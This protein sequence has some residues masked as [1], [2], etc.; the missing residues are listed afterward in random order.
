METENLSR[1]PQ[2]FSSMGEISSQQLGWRIAV[3][4]FRSE[5]A[6]AGYE[7][8]LGMAEEISAAFSRYRSPR[9]ISPVTFWDGAGPSADFIGRCQFY[10]LD[11]VIEGTIQ[12]IADKIHVDVM[13]S[14][15]V[16][17]FEAIWGGS[18]DGRMDDLCYLQ[19]RIVAVAISQ[20]DPDLLQKALPVNPLVRTKIAAAHQAVL[21]AIQW[22][23]QLDRAQFMRAGELLAVAIELDPEYAAAH[24]WIAYWSIIAVSLGWASKPRA[25]AIAAGKSA[26]R[27]IL[28]NPSNARALAIAGHV[29]G[30][31][32]HDVSAALALHERAIDLDPNLAI[33]WAL[34]SWSKIY[35]GEHATAIKHALM[36]QTLSPRDPNLFFSE[37][38]IM[39]AHL[40]KG[41]LA[42][43][44][45]LSK[46][47][48]AKSSGHA[49]ALNIR[50]SILGHMGRAEEAVECLAALNNLS[51]NVTISAIT[52][53][54]PWKHEDHIFY[55]E[56]LRRAGVPE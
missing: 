10:K 5:G 29:K 41:Q 15:V 11:Y 9:L 48:S 19:N 23:L 12:V 56:G 34:S 18:F 32:F 27:A 54:A 33:A 20:L 52:A 25:V 51:N 6:A 2:V 14:D 42:E 24:T 38:A 46:A 7:I 37:H 4:P 26:E 1:F 22:I 36:A 40:F 16:L 53:R 45:T 13:L 55:A 21:T 49:A 8:A 47:V 17:G 35:N 30:Y 50:L 3:L 31:L 44:E 39:A 43:A 28:L